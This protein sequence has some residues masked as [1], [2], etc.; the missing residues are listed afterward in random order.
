M[1]M[2]RARVEGDPKLDAAIRDVG[3]IYRRAMQQATT[4][5]DQLE[6]GS[7]HT[8]L[9]QFLHAETPPES[10]A[11]L[12]CL[13]LTLEDALRLPMLEHLSGLPSASLSQV[14]FSANAMLRVTTGAQDH[15]WVDGSGEQLTFPDGSSFLHHLVSTSPAAAGV[16]EGVVVDWFVPGLEGD[17]P[18]RIFS[19]PSMASL[20]DTPGLLDV[21][22]RGASLLVLA[23]TPREALSNTR[24]EQIKELSSL[25]SLVVPVV[26]GEVSDSRALSMWPAAGAFGTTPALKPVS[27]DLA[28][29]VPALPESLRSVHPLR[30]AIVWARAARELHVAS[31]LIDRRIEEETAAIETQKA[32]LATLVP[33]R[34]TGPDPVVRK[35]FDELRERVQAHTARLNRLAQDASRR[36]T[37]PGSDLLVAIEKAA[38]RLRWRDLVDED[39]GKV[40]R[41][42]LHEGHVLRIAEV[43]RSN[44]K[45]KMSTI[46]GAVRDAWTEIGAQ[47]QSFRD[48]TGHLLAD[49]DL[50]VPSD[51]EVWAV[52]R[53]HMKLNIKYASERPKRNFLHRLG[54]GRRVMFA[55][56]MAVSMTTMMGIKGI[57][58]SLGPVLGA[59]MAALLIWGVYRTYGEWSREDAE[60]AEKELER[61]KEALRTEAKRTASDGMREI[62]AKLSEDVGSETKGL[63]KSIEGSFKR[64]AESER[65]ASETARTQAQEQARMLDQAARAL[66]GY[67]QQTGKLRQSVGELDM[68]LTKVVREAQRYTPPNSDEPRDASAGAAS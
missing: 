1:A 28:G 32:I 48:S 56:M 43:V 51:A 10:S 53:P 60:F 39:R 7:A 5:A 22:A 4:L 66:A 50:R 49:A 20:R 13:L 57:R 19:P 31:G 9:G 33:A 16:A 21:A 37:Q 35:S 34:T 3:S 12:C 23:G 61:A 59:G 52:A 25:F 29:G 14:V 54:E 63:L 15:A 47:V 44:V 42:S 26:V 27:V 38:D 30:D 62:A 41:Y 24:K 58:E 8:P 64:L 36:A 68:S 18:L 17:E 6:R 45:R 46:L 2:S 11:P 40:I 65:H 67:N 55:L